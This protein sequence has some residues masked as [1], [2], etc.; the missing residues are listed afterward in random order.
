MVRKMLHQSNKT[1]P[2]D[3]ALIA[4]CSATMGI[5][6]TALNPKNLQGLRDITRLK[7]SYS[8][9]VT[10]IKNHLTT[11]TIRVPRVC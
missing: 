10:S 1:G 9:D 11:F 7:T 4:K 8:E 2:L 6:P 5:E 3:Y